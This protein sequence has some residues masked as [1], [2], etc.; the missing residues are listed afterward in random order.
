MTKLNTITKRVFFPPPE[1]PTHEAARRVSAVRLTDA[2]RS[3]H[4][5]IFWAKLPVS[6]SSQYSRARSQTVR[7]G[8]KQLEVKCRGV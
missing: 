6:G 2:A 4:N 1:V 7:G 8:Q 5:F 3:L